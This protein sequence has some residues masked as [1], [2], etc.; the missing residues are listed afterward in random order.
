MN[1]NII[2]DSDY[3]CNKLNEGKEEKI[4]ALF[5]FMKNMSN[6]IIIQDNDQNIVRN[7][8]KNEKIKEQEIKQTEIFLSALIQGTNKYDFVTNIKYENN[9]IEFVKNLKEKNYPIQIIISDKKIDEKTKS[10]LIENTEEI[11]KIISLSLS[12]T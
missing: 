7:I 9:F 10:Y 2:L 12:K 1:V 6:I 3:I 5:T 11:I 4:N 8:I